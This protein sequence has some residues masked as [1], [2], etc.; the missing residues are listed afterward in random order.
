MAMQAYIM[1]ELMS[2]AQIKYVRDVVADNGSG[3]KYYQYANTTGNKFADQTG[4]G[5]VYG[6]YQ[7]LITNFEDSNKFLNFPESGGATKY[8]SRP[9]YEQGIGKGGFNNTYIAKQAISRIF[10]VERWAMLDNNL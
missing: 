2:G 5:K 3:G 1:I 4:A 6:D 9:N 10:V 8:L 7:T